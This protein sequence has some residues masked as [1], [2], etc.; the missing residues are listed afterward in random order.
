MKWG[1]LAT[2]AIASKFAKTIGAMAAEGEYVVAVGSRNLEK[3]K[4]FARDHGIVR[5]Y[6]SYEELLADSDVAKSSTFIAAQLNL[7]PL[8]VI[9]PMG[10]RT[11]A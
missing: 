11:Y 4:D 2:G 5:A 7:S 9:P 8:P 10:V 1:I 3:A 6:G